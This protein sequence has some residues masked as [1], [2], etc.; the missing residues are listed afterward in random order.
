MKFHTI[1]PSIC[2]HENICNFTKFHW[3][4]ICTQILCSPVLFYTYQL[5][6]IAWNF[7]EITVKF[8]EL[9]NEI[10]SEIS[11]KFHEIVYVCTKTLIRWNF[12]KFHIV[13]FHVNFMKYQ[14]NFIP[15]TETAILWYI[16]WRNIF[17]ETGKIYRFF[18]FLWKLTVR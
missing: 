10:N 18:S 17:Y 8:H 3:N 9:F 16:Y 14:W 5:D 4:F 13:K 7:S 11:V 6:M 1:M 12:M 2:I 15:P